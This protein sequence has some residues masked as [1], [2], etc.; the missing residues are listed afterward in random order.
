M[1]SG[2]IHIQSDAPLPPYNELYPSQ[3]DIWG[4]G[5]L[6]QVGPQDSVEALRARSWPELYLLSALPMP[7]LTGGP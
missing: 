6:Q 2:S 1:F 5:K 4:L 7:T 3:L